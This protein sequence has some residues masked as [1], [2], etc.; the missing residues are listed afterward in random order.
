MFLLLSCRGEMIQFC[1]IISDINFGPQMAVLL[2]FSFIEVPQQFLIFLRII[3]VNYA[4]GII[5][6]TE[7]MKHLIESKYLKHIFKGER[8]QNIKICKDKSPQY[9]SNHSF[10]CNIVL[11]IIQ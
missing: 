4:S 5:G 6:I 3:F 11:Y 9:V 8:Q 10:G 1:I 7:R 2:K